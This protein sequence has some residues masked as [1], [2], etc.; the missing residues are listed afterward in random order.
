MKKLL[1]ISAILMMVF[2]VKTEA[3]PRHNDVDFNFFYSSLSPY[4]EWIEI[5][6][7]VYAWRPVGIRHH[8]R[9][10]SDGRWEWTSYGWYWDSYEPFGWATFHYGRWY[11]DDYYGWMW[12]PDNEWGPAWVDWRY[13]DDYIGWSPLPPYAYFGIDF[14][15]HFSIN[16]F[17]PVHYWNFVR[18][19]HFCGYDVHNYFVDDKYRNDIFK[20]TKYRNDYGYRDGRVIN[21]GVDRDFVER[22]SGSRITER[23]VVNS[24]RLRDNNGNRNRDSRVEVYRPSDDDI[25][26]T[27]NIEKFEIRKSEKTTNLDL[28][29]VEKNRIVRPDSKITERTVIKNENKNPEILNRTEKN[30]KINVERNIK[31]N[32]ERSIQNNRESRIENKVNTETRIMKRSN[33]VE[34]KS[35]SRNF[36]V[37]KPQN[38]NR[39]IEKRSNENNRNETR[40]I[41]KRSNDNKR[42]ESRIVE[43][44][45]NNSRTNNSNRDEKS[46]TRSR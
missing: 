39:T 23:E 41:E 32:E 31:R 42:N 18:Y 34:T 45:T 11:Y 40:T 22:R 28:R 44:S 6:N 43:R 24:T 25:K 17:A 12:L 5:N 38:E 19:N 9:P 20:H 2:L 7:D 21:R 37:N 13:D 26:R 46:K 27:R 36:N 15:I 8:W 35:D 10:Y 16:W 29:K 3:N 14:G 4:G 30:N 33:D 1:L